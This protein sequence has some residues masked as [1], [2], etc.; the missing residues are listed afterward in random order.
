M[1]V[2]F[3]EQRVGRDEK[4]KQRLLVSWLDQHWGENVLISFL[5]PSTAYMQSTSCKMLGWIK[6]KLNQ[7][8]REK[9]HQPQICRWPSPL[10]QEL[11]PLDESESGKWKT[12]LKH[13]QQAIFLNSKSC[14]QFIGLWCREHSEL[15]FS[16]S[17]PLLNRS[18]NIQLSKPAIPPSV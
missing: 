12:G 13:C 7:D 9:Y 17:K 5:Q 11:K 14:L 2:S 1:L 8:F 16:S 15:G 10:W 3:I 6:H 18:F 4:V